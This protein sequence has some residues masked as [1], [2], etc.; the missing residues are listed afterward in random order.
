ME[1]TWTATVVEHHRLRHDLAVVRLVGDHVPFEPG[2][3]VDVSVP[4][5]PRLL[6]RLSPA[7]PPSLDGKLE[8]H[9]RSVPGGWV[10]GTI[11]AD[12]APGDTWQIMDPRGAMSVD[13]SGR[14]VVMIAGGTGLA[15]FRSILL[16][17]SRR[18]NPPKVFLFIGD[19]TPRDLYA[20]DMLY[21]LLRDLPWLTVIPVVE[22]VYDPEWGDEWYESVRSDIG[23]GV[24]DLI[25]GT[26]P[27]V[28]TSYGA[29]V[30]HQVLVCGS[31]A[32]VRATLD[33]LHATGTPEENILYDPY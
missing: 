32:M 19:R 20:S 26:L 12:T 3:Y 25:E 7:L 23:F 31:A 4:Q 30:D 33:R 6:R 8:F 5:N 27:D 16:D 22:S 10:S 2:Q 1:S 17:L 9:V 13:D 14:D 15:P 11:V 24:D 29:F 21:L 28:V 18:E